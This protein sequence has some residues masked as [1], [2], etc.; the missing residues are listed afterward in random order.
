MRKKSWIAALLTVI[1]ATGLTV[2]PVEQAMAIGSGGTGARSYTA[3]EG[4]IFLGGNY[5]EI[6]ISDVG[7]YGTSVGAPYKPSDPVYFHPLSMRNDFLRYSIGLRSNGGGWETGTPEKTCDFFLPGTIDEGF[8]TFWS[9]SESGTPSYNAGGS[10]I[11]SRSALKKN[12]ENQQTVDQ[13]SSSLLKA[14]TTGDMGTSELGTLS[15]EQ[16][17]TF[18]PD[19]KQFKT[20][21][22]LKNTCTQA[23]YK[24][25][26]LRKFDPDQ[27]AINRENKTDNYFLNDESGGWWAIASTKNTNGV[28]TSLTPID[29]HTYFSNCENVFCFY[30]DDLRSEAITGELSFITLNGDGVGK[31][32]D[33]QHCY[34]DKAIGLR[35]NI[36][37]LQPGESATFEYYSSL[38]PDVEGAVSKAEDVVINITQQPISRTFSQGSITGK[39]RVRGEVLISG[40]P[41]DALAYQWYQSNSASTTGG[42]PLPGE[43]SSD[44]IIPTT[45]KATNDYYY[46]CVVSGAGQEATTQLATIHIVPANSTIHAVKFDANTTGTVSGMPPKQTVVNGGLVAPVMDPTNTKANETYFKGWYKDSAC[47]S[48]WDFANE[49]VTSALTLYAGWGKPP[50]LVITTSSLP[51]G[52][53]LAEYHALI[54]YSYDGSKSVLLTVGGLPNGL[55]FNAATR[56]I[57]GTPAAATASAT[58]YRVIIRAQ[59]NGS[60]RPLKTEKELPLFVGVMPVITLDPGHGSQTIPAGSPVTFSATATGLPAPTYAWQVWDP[61]NSAWANID[62]ATQSTYTIAKTTPDMNGSQYQCIATNS[63]GNAKTDIATLTVQEAPTV[64]ITPESYTILQGSGKTATFT[65]AVTGQ[66]APRLQW[67]QATEG[68]NWMDIPGATSSTY[69]VSDPLFSMNGFRFRCAA[70]N[71]AVTE[72][73]FSKP[74]TLIVQ[75][76]PV[77]DTA[78]PAD[79]TIGA[80]GTAVFT[81]TVTGTAP[82]HYQW[83]SRSSASAGWVNLGTNS[84]TLALTNVAFNQNQSQ[85]QCIVSNGFEPAATSRTATLTVNAGVYII[86]Q[87]EDVTVAVGDSASFSI[88]ASGT[89]P[90]SY[91]WQSWN[92]NTSTWEKLDGATS[93]QLNILATTFDMNGSKFRCNATNTVSGIV[94]TLDSEEAVLTV[95][96]APFIITPPADQ[97]VLAPATAS[98]EI[99]AQG[100]QPLLYQWQVSTDNGATFLDVT[101]GTGMNTNKYTTPA[102]DYLMSAFLYRCVVS[103]GIQPPVVSA[104]AKLTVNAAVAILKH[105]RSIT[106]F[107]AQKPSFSILANGTM[108]LT[109]QWQC[110]LGG[111]APWANLKGETSPTLQLGAMYLNQN[112]NRYRCMVTNVYGT[113]FSNPAELT[114]L[115]NQF[116]PQTGDD[117]PILPLSMMLL[118]SALCGIGLYWMRKRF[119]HK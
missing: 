106:I 80:G 110:S 71:D 2:L 25:Y 75:R 55:T 93:P 62:G 44:F 50:T 98:F 74:S 6:G 111:K 39:L 3:A 57:S 51:N 76:W 4:N 58:P 107:E 35:F 81:V 8:T 105:P 36:G 104:A 109:Y 78:F 114:V 34:D 43:T 49:R 27:N 72:P 94:Y 88:E 53:E 42:T 90:I 113:I 17:V 68:E 89:M 95:T 21:I 28:G 102:T 23:L 82:F 26:Y 5:I 24:L 31:A 7:S 12:I 119:A 61:V 73:V 115:Y 22:T 101:D 11:A 67:Q 45:L 54:D 41:T 96:S 10:K 117:T 52:A 103:N 63:V 46:Y 48:K 64:V 56:E 100:T 38:D 84:D 118:C 14:V 1:L 97:T 59:E 79:L 92:N 91:Q 83:Q 87:P 60:I 19:D 85:Y 66:P 33:G 116:L 15:Y 18:Q 37:T 16:I 13:S 47:T 77:L 32:I 70:I 99:T 112:G 69:S 9:T 65:A 108:P 30:S 29:R 86:T 40:V 20:V